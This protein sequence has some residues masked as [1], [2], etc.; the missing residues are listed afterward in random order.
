MWVIVMLILIPLII[1]FICET[2]MPLVIV[3]IL[4]IFA[5]PLLVLFNSIIRKWITD[6]SMD[7]TEYEK[8]IKQKQREHRIAQVKAQE[9]YDNDWGYIR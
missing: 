4:S 8:Q 9:K 3:L 6:G 1:W 5:I 7:K 2:G